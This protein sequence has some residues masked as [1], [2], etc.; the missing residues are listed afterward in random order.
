MQWS[1]CG[2]LR[3]QRTARFV[4]TLLTA[5]TW[6]ESCAPKDARSAGAARFT[7][8]L[9][10]PQSM[11]KA[12]RIETPEKPQAPV[13]QFCFELASNDFVYGDLL[14]VSDAEIAVSSATL[15][16]LRLSRD[17][18]RRIYRYKGADS[19]YLGPNGIA[20]W[21]EKARGGQWIDDG[22]Q[23]LTNQSGASLY[24]DLGIPERARIK[25][26]LSW[27][28]KPDF[29][30]GLGVD[31]KE[32]APRGMHFEVWD[33][34]L[35]AVAE[36]A[37]EA[38]VAP[39]QKI[40]GGPGRL[41]IQAFLDQ[42][43]GQLV[44]LSPTGRVLAT[45]NTHAKTPR[46]QRGVRLTNGRG[47]IRLESI[48]IG[49]WNGELPREAKADQPRLHRTDG[50]IVYGR[51]TGYDAKQKQFKLRDGSTDT[52]VNQDA[53]GDLLLMPAA[54]QERAPGPD[55]KKKSVPQ[56]TAPAEKKSPSLT[57]LME[58]PNA[59]IENDPR[60]KALR[61]DRANQ[62]KMDR[63]RPT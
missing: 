45:L 55:E 24:S 6:S 27:N 5:A 28:V 53:V 58:G 15:G 47:D 38:D 40:V 62:P 21:K 37:R 32:T 25:I 41:R 18:L 2:R 3:Q 26:E 16:K 33:Q 1:R 7:K 10:F 8:P 49:R 46:V 30:L 54:D 31:E 60:A 52:V 17:Q 23:L 39:L 4:L 12:V 13:G 56:E 36:S 51:L 34:D 14:E 22:G 43:Q 42:A 61:R 19:I 59:V 9:E 29:V 50:S 48:R 57:D 63:S 44:L 35:V 20:G 11:L